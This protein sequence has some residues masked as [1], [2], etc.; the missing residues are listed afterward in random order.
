MVW[1]F[2]P[3]KWSKINFSLQYPCT[4]HQTGYEN[5]QIY[6]VEVIILIW[7]QIL[8]TYLQ[9]NVRQLEGRINNQILGVRGLN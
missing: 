5:T 2:N 6:L 4:I 1:P 8:T 3:Q 7:H 9:G